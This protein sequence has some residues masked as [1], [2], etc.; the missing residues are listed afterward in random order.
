MDVLATMAFEEQMTRVANALRNQ[1]RVVYARP[2]SLIPPEKV[3]VTAAKAGFE[4]HGMP[5]RGQRAR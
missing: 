2:E 4:A 5:A 1:F 3:T